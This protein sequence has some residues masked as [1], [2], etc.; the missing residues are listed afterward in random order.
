MAF[1]CVR[2]QGPQY[3]IQNLVVPIHS[4]GTFFQ[5]QSAKQRDMIVTR[6]HTSHYWPCNFHFPVQNS[7][8]RPFVFTEIRPL[9][10]KSTKDM[11]LW[12]LMMHYINRP[13][14]FEWLIAS[15]CLPWGLM[16]QDALGL[17]SKTLALALA[18]TDL[19]WLSL[20]LHCCYHQTS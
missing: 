7:V 19:T 16:E 4:A 6:M 11:C 9:G 8:E 17:V 10:F 12:E 15:G 3:W 20:G 2:V 13:F 1:D 5:L 18:L 14:D